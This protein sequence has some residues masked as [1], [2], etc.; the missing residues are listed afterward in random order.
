[1]YQSTSVSF[2]YQMVGGRL[3]TPLAVT[4]TA[5]CGRSLGSLAPMDHPCPSSGW[6][7]N[8]EDKIASLNYLFIIVQ[9]SQIM[10]LLN[11]CYSKLREKVILDPNDFH[12]LV[13]KIKLQACKIIQ[14]LN[15]IKFMKLYSVTNI[16][17]LATFW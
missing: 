16:A 10:S 17:N 6:H 5:D 1:M 13:N 8:L 7:L 12:Y 11:C 3:D 15:Q 2:L 9:L 14:T 4:I